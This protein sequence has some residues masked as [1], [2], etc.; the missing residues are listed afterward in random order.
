VRQVR[1]LLLTRK[2]DCI[3]FYIQPLSIVLIRADKIGL[4]FTIEIAVTG[5]HKEGETSVLVFGD[6]ASFPIR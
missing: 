5:D 3:I 1:S 2:R 4:D 6:I